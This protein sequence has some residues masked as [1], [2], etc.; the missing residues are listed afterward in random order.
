MEAEWSADRANLRLAVREHPEWS[1]PQLAQQFGRSVSWVK[2][3][4]QRLRAAPLDDEAVLH[5]RPRARKHPTPGV[6]QLVIER[7]LAIRDE[8]PA[9]LQRVPGPKAIR[10]CLQQDPDLQAV[11]LSPPRST[12]TVWRVLRRHARI[13]QRRRPPHEPVDLP[14]PLTSWQLDFK[15]VSSVPSEP[16]GKRQHGVE[17][18]N[19]VDGGTSLLVAADVR[20][21]FTEATTLTAIAELLQAHGRPLEITLDRDP[22][23][24]GAPGA[25]DFPSPLIRFLACL[26]VTVHINPPHRPDSNSFVERYHGSFDRECLQV[27][28]PGTLEQAREV[29]ATFQTHYHTERPNQARSCG[30]RPPRV[31]FPEL[32]PCPPLPMLVDPDAWLRLIDGRRYVRQVQADGSVIIEHARYYVGRRLA[33]QRVVLAVAA[34]ERALVAYHGDRPLKHLPLHGLRGEVLPFDH[35]VA[36]MEREARAQ[37]RRRQRLA[38]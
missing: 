20:A 12:A 34:A 15:D 7:I 30:N 3:W 28:R 26:G 16:L 11:G 32:P 25:G 5:G 4:R 29:T 22:R 18:L 13:P 1:A 19:C 14:P 38:A 36:L 37:A 27:H 21:D 24:V 23:F 35:Y 9:N 17:A 10:Y 33:G 8:P 2:K 31:A 6:S